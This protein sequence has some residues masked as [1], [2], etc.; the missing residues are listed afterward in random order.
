MPQYVQVKN[1]TTN[2]P[3]ISRMENQVA[4]DWINRHNADP[5]T[6]GQYEILAPVRIEVTPQKIETEKKSQDVAASEVTVTA[7]EKK[8]KKS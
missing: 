1:N 6:K 3:T 8:S 4:I 2:P 5:K 7:P